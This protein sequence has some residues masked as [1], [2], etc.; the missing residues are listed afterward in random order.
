MAM[1]TLTD[2][3]QAKAE[4]RR[5][6]ILGVLCFSL[7]V[8]V[9]DNSILNV[10]LPSI[11][12]QLNATNSQLQWMVDSY[13]LVFAGLLLTMGSLG[14]KFGR[15]P[16]LQ[17]GFVVFGAGSLLSALSS[18][19]DQ[20]I[21]SRA[22]MGIGGALIMP[23]TLSII[24]NVFPANE[25]P[26]AIG[27]WAATAGVGVALGPL[28]GGALL[29]RFYW[30]SIFLVNLP[31]V[32]IGL[33]AGVY[34]IPNSKDPNAPRLDLI[35]AVLSIAS[36]SSLLYAVIEA[37]TKGWTAP[38]ILVFFFAGGILLAAFFWWEQRVDHPMLDVGFWKNPRFSGASAAIAITFFAMFG[39][40]FLLTQY[41]QFVLGYSPL[42]T[43][44]RLLAFAIPMMVIS[45]I[46]PRIVDRIGTK[47]TV[48]AGLACV[49]GGLLALASVGATTAFVD[50]AWRM[51]LAATGMAL[52][53]SPATESIMGSLP[54]SRAGVG[55]AVN[56]TTRQ[57]GGAVGV[58]V[59]GSVFSSIYGSKVVDALRGKPIPASVVENAKQQL[60]YALA[61]AGHLPAQAARVFVALAKSSFI[62]G[63]H[64]GL[65]VGAASAALGVVLVLVY[66]PS[67]P[68]SEDVE[69]QT[70]EFD[71][72]RRDRVAAAA[73]A[74]ANDA[75][76]VG[77]PTA[78]GDGYR[79]APAR[80]PTP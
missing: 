56:D 31:I 46:S 24:T 50:I 45:P 40:I 18:T 55:S 77:T 48:G 72:N 69:R 49:T 34:L 54:L 42:S 35:G 30:G 13:T 33:I 80:A 47:L 2:R 36:L 32:A 62:D 10:A 64:A 17:A 68:R 11:V 67:R 29:E 41:L 51:A 43:G 53:M 73:A 71:G 60:G 74:A 37:P 27:F 16:A 21:A 8:I 7:L 76:P 79:P 6:L 19:P 22:F 66:L 5:W 23:A 3:V 52:T 4:E 14:D 58:A 57:V 63:F 1:T 78:G 61:A 20:L 44:V 65:Y 12:R 9:L 28:A 38:E 75:V 70:N 26:K 25:R 15:R 39:S 59:I